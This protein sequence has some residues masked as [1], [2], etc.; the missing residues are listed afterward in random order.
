MVFFFLPLPFSPCLPPPHV[1]YLR[2]YKVPRC[3]PSSQ[4]EER[5]LAS[6][7]APCRHVR[8]KRH[9]ALDRTSASPPHKLLHRAM[10]VGMCEDSG[11]GWMEVVTPTSDAS[12]AEAGPCF[13]VLPRFALRKRRSS[14]LACVACW[15]GWLGGATT[16]V[17]EGLDPQQHEICYWAEFES[18]PKAHGTT[19]HGGGEKKCV[20]GLGQCAHD[21][22]LYLDTTNRAT[23]WIV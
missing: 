10:G 21:S 18:G 19:A 2:F 9:L 8:S 13:A 15:L 23:W 12:P 5:F 22:A 14:S 4:V 16:S 17:W 7:G 11:G 20:C 6:H 1:Q 3:M